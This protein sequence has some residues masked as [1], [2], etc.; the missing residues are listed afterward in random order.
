[1][2]LTTLKAK[3]L[4]W[5]TVAGLDLRIALLMSNTT[6]DTE[7]APATLSGYTLLDELDAVGYARKPLVN[8]ALVEDGP[9]N[10]VEIHADNLV[11]AGLATGTRQVVGALVYSHVTN[12]ADSVPIAFLDGVDF[13]LDGAGADLT[14]AFPSG[15]VLSDLGV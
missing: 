14:L 11:F 6:A 5:A 3:S 7:A 9:G 10:K 8:A 13:P 15:V 4:A 12:D 2:S 1:M